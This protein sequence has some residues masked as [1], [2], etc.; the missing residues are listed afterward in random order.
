MLIIFKDE[1]CDKI[2]Q[3]D[4]A[5][6]EK[7]RQSNPQYKKDTLTKVENKEIDDITSEEEDGEGQEIKQELKQEL[8]I[9]QEL[10]ELKE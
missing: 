5:N 4:L 7:S 10:Q 3:E 1:A 8:S 2:K 9:K 6:S